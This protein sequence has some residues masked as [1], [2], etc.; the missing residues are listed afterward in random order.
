MILAA[1]RAVGIHFQV[2]SWR[3]AAPQDRYSSTRLR[4]ANCRLFHPTCDALIELQ[5][6]SLHHLDLRH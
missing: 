3:D 6:L 2:E 5:T 1:G 4:T